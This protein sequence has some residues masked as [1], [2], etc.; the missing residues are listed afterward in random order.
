M[1][2]PPLPVPLF[3]G[4]Q[5]D[6]KHNFQD[7][8]SERISPYKKA[9]GAA[10]GNGSVEDSLGYLKYSHL[11]HLPDSLFPPTHLARPAFPAP[12]FLYSG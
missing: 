9:V 8:E 7:D 2:Y 6:D 1:L 12:T 10:G 4:R 5:H 3:F 11:I